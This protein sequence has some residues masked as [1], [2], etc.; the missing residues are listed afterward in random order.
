ML[1]QKEM[2]IVKTAEREQLPV[3]KPFVPFFFLSC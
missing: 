2:R 1:V 3:K